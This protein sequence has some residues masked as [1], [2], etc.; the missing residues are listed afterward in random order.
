MHIWI[1]RRD[2]TIFWSF[3]PYCFTAN[4]HVIRSRHITIH[5][6]ANIFVFHVLCC[7]EVNNKGSNCI[8]D[9]LLITLYTECFVWSVITHTCHNFK[10]GVTSHEDVRIWMKMWCQCISNFVVTCGVFYSEAKLTKETFNKTCFFLC[11]HNCKRRWFISL[12]H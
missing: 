10:G 11:C 12:S 5:L 7:L 9:G 4:R 2:Y 3:H 8:W 1:K 6:L